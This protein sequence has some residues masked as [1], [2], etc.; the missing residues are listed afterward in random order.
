MK[1]IALIITLFMVTL[2][3]S[4]AKGGH[5]HSSSSHSSSHPKKSVHVSASR[6]KDGRTIR[7]HN[8]VP[9]GQRVGRSHHKGG[10]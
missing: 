7:A 5:S 2:T 1:H 9:A 10:K 8:R 4:Y 3:P 6:R